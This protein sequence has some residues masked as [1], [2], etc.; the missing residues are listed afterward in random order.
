M[1][2]IKSRMSVHFGLLT[3]AAVLALESLFLLALWYSW[4]ENAE[5]MALRQASL[6]SDHYHRFAPR[7]LPELAQQVLE[8][9]KEEHPFDVQVIDLHGRIIADS[10]GM[11]SGEPVT[12]ADV[13]SALAG[14]TGIWRG[15]MPGTGEAVLAV[16][17]PVRIGEQQAGVLRHVTSTRYLDQALFRIAV[18]SMAVSFG[19]ILLAMFLSRLIASRIVRPIRELTR[20]AGEISSGNFSARAVK[21]DDDEIG[22]L[23]ETMNAMS[24]ELAKMEQLKNEFISSVSHELRTPL[25]AL[26]GWGETFRSGSLSKEDEIY[27]LSV[28]EKETE[29]LIGLVEDLLDFSKYQSGKIELRKEPFDLVEVVEETVAQFRRLSE[30]K[31]IWLSSETDSRSLVI[32]G[33][34][35]RLKQVLVNLLDNSVKFTPDGGTISLVIGKVSDSIRIVV[36]DT[37]IGIPADDLS[38][39]MDKFYKGR[40]EQGGSGLGL[41]ICKE[42]IRL[43]EGKIE[44]ESQEGAGT[45]F[46]V[47]LPVA[48]NEED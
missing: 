17:L 25:T 45:T 48:A 32:K 3:A 34:R 27:G 18:V 5:K 44:V 12:A 9:R 16:S 2:S 39:I 43:H 35:H 37:G 28:M 46:T 21:A 26:K 4:Y 33:D 47:T 6:A 1:R 19:V 42:I 14:R 20:V 24:R 10:W 22:V 11:P 7:S 38:R 30:R 8:E 36:S 31:S 23:A 29:R 41:A 13:R 40:S 15:E